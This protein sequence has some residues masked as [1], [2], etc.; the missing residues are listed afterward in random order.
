VLSFR[1]ARHDVMAEDFGVD[2][3]RLAAAFPLRRGEA[4]YLAVLLPGPPEPLSVAATVAWST[5]RPPHRTG[6]SFARAGAGERARRL[7]DLLARDPSLSRVRV[8]LRPDQRLRLG[9]SPPPGVVLGRD[10]LAVLRAAR[11]GTTALGLLESAGPRFREVRSALEALRAQGLVHEALH[12]PPAPGWVG[13]LGLEAPAPP[14]PEPQPASPFAPLGRPVRALC[15][16]EA[17]R[18][19]GANGHLGA[20][21]EWLQRALECAPGDPEISGALEAL[22]GGDG[23]R[24]A[25]GRPRAAD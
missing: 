2:G 14:P 6:L 7:R 1:G 24:A 17:A 21:V 22:T 18:D 16:L 9:P 8:P 25:A 10:E 12:A 13:L 3:C 15:F 11:D 23:D 5:S 4:V 20:A 19:E